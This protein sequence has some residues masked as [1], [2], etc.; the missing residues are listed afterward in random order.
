MRILNKLL[1]QNRLKTNLECVF[2]HLIVCSALK[3]QFF[4]QEILGEERLPTGSHEENNALNLSTLGRSFVG[5]I[6]PTEGWKVPIFSAESAGPPTFGS[7]VGWTLAFFTPPSSCS[8]SSSYSPGILAA[9]LES[10]H[11]LSSMALIS[12]RSLRASPFPSVS[13]R[14]SAAIFVIV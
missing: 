13:K 3:R 1:A 7:V 4:S 12:F 14:F 10:Y 6:F 9:F 8:S 11:L 2:K 5:W